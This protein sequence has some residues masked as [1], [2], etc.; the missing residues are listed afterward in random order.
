MKKNVLISINPDAHSMEGVNDIRYGVY[1][2]RKG[3]LTKNFTL[4]TFSKDEVAA[5]FAKKK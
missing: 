4:N 2:A 3:M 1:A 5:Y